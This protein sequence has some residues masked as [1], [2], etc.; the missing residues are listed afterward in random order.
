MVVNQLVAEAE[1]S[2]KVQTAQGAELEQVRRVAE[3]TR[4]QLNGAKISLGIHKAKAQ[5]LLREMEQ[6][7]N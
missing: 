2:R 6:R 7:L 4:R 5:K 3:Q 1:R